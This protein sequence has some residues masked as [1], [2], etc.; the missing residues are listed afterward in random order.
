MSIKRNVLSAFVSAL[1]CVGFAQSAEP[2]MW[3]LTDRSDTAY[4]LGSIHLGSADFYP[5]TP[6]IETAFEESP[7]LLVEI[8][9]SDPEVVQEVEGLTLAE[10]LYPDGET[11]WDNISP[12]TAES[13]NAFCDELGIPSAA[14]NETFATLEPWLASL[15]SG[16]LPMMMQGFDMESGVDTYF[17]NKAKE[18]DKEIV[19][20][21]N[22]I[23]QV[24]LFSDE[25][26][27]LMEIYLK[28]GIDYLIEN[29]DFFQSLVDE[30][31]EGDVAGLT[32]LFE[33]S[34]DTDTPEIAD[35]ERKLL[36]DRNVIMADAVEQT[37]GDDE[38]AF[39]VVGVAH[40]LGE[41]SVID[42]LEERGYE[43]TQV[44]TAQ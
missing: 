5:L 27:E 24:N 9:L 21:E 41:E 32:E 33:A 2:V 12:E 19:E 23:D 4:V 39:V 36:Q 29:P 31:V 10:G 30:Y 37:L 34:V 17:L 6:E 44:E 42:L 35:F 26:P 13:L 7:T 8:D 1:M 11:L 28:E 14:C 43:V 40:L 25:P 3:E 38:P 20:I 22:V 15:T 16:V 18:T